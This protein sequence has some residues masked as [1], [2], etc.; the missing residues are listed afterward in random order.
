M[1]AWG[2]TPARGRLRFCGTC[3]AVVAFAEERRP[4]VVEQAEADRATLGINV[5]FT[6]YPEC[7][8]GSTFEGEAIA[9]CR[10]RRAMRLPREHGLFCARCDGLISPDV[11]GEPRRRSRRKGG[12]R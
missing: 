7:R 1:T 6:L 3:G 2:V 8:R 5:H 9:A 10:C 11:A 4:G 12:R